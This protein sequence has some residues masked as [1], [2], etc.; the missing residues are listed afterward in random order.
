MIIYKKI[1]IKS[2]SV[3]SDRHLGVHHKQSKSTNRI[4]NMSTKKRSLS[5]R[6]LE[7][8][9]W[10]SEGKTDWEIGVILSISIYTVKNHVKSILSKLDACNR[11]H[12]TQKANKMGIRQ[13][14]API[15]NAS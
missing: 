14:A 9:H 12:A 3:G 15:A 7:V 4:S 8:L 5:K 10:V 11:T 1:I 2:T 13:A 6:E